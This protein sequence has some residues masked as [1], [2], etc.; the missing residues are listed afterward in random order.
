[1]VRQFVTICTLGVAMMVLLSALV[2]AEEIQGTVS[3]VDD[4]GMATI[5]TTDGKELKVALTGVKAGDK[6]D[7]HTTKEGKASCHLAFRTLIRHYEAFLADQSRDRGEKAVTRSFT[8][9]NVLF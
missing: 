3:A 2:L 8:G 4:K 5:K 1:M 9:C 6:V 7:C